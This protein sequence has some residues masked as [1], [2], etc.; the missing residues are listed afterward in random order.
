MDSE[1]A[2]VI[3]GAGPT[4][5]GA[6]W[7]LEELGYKNWQLFEAVDVPGGLAS[8]VVD[9]RGF[10]WDQGGHVLFS[11]YSYFDC[12]MEKL[13]GDSWISHIRESW[14]WMRN[15]FIPYPLQNNIWRLPEDDLIKCLNGLL[16]VQGNGRPRPETFREWILDNF[17]PGL[18]DVFLLPYNFKVWAFD[19]AA[20]GTGWMGERVATVDLERVLENLVRKKDDYG[21]GPNAQF[22]FPLRGGTGAIW[23]ALYDRLPAN[24]L[25]LGKRV[26]EVSAANRSIKFADGTLTRYDY[27]ISTIPLDCLLRVLSNRPELTRK[28]EEF[29][30]S[31]SHIVGVGLQG[32]VPPALSTKCWMYFPEPDVPFYRV[33]VFSNYSPYNVPEPGSQWSLLCEVSE[34]AAKPVD[35]ERLTDDVLAGL[36]RVQ[37]IANDASIV[38]IWHRRLGYGYPTPFLGRDELLESIDPQLQEMGIWSRGRFGAWKYEVSNQDHSIMQGVEAVDHILS[39]TEETTYHYPDLVNASKDGGR[40]RSEQSGNGH[41]QLLTQAKR[42]NPFEL[43]AGSDFEQIKPLLTVAICTFNRATLLPRA[44][45]SVRNQTRAS[46]DLEIL[47]VDNSSTDGTRELVAAVQA[48]DSRVRYVVEPKAGIA[49][50]RNCALREARGEYLA[51]LDDDAWAECD[52]LENLLCAILSITPN[53]ECVVGPVSLVWEGK[54]PDWFPTRFES[55]LCRYDMGEKPRFL[56]PGGYLLTT[57]SLFHRQTLLAL[58]GLRDDLGHKRNQLI[59]GED[60]EIFQRLIANGYHVYYQ[61]T[62]RV[63]HPVPRERQTRRYLLRRLFWD[64]ASQPLVDAVRKEDKDASRAGLELYR[65]SRRLLRFFL[66]ILGEIATGDRAGAQDGVYRLVQGAGRMRTH[67]LMALGAR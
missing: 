2:I 66:E 46:A 55:L 24:R 23:R 20:L 64:G 38:S 15:Q 29:K 14:V 49:H 18:A 59:G 40:K 16:A 32:P 57:N 8:S 45:D 58:G 47:V 30:F 3:I 62:A 67:L 34:S 9:D 44:V 7:H 31:S 27:L 22:R 65:D 56:D 21:W 26:V 19:P 63:N 35:H 10:T 6:A 1:R 51:F 42:P 53:P 28:A 11:H 54:R 41:G 5:L 48:E 52:W 60:N 17:G 39:G 37:L 36:R 43:R 33:T 13:L 12:L 50:A 61:P 4:G 25:E